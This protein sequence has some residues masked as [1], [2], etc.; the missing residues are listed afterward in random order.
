MTG[1]GRCKL[2]DA[3]ASRERYARNRDARR[4]TMRA[5]QDTFE[6]WCRNVYSSIT[7]RCDGRSPDAA[8]WYK[9]VSYCSWDEFWQWAAGQRA[10]W[11]D[12]MAQ[13]RRTQARKDRPSVDRLSSDKG[14][15]PTNMR[16]APMWEN[17]KRAA[18]Q[19]WHGEEAA[20]VNT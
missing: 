14:Y 11:E 6:G 15:L 20:R 3:A 2:L 10:V 1:K 9:G 16:F 19:R 5:Y 12:I 18:V 7:A 8:R 13:F 4:A 17:S